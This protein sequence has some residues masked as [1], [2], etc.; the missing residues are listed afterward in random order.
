MRNLIWSVLLATCFGC[1]D[2]RPPAEVHVSRDSFPDF[3]DHRIVPEAAEDWSIMPFA[4]QGA[5]FGFGLPTDSGDPGVGFTGPFLTTTG[6]WF[7]PQLVRLEIPGAELV[8]ARALP[9]LLTAGWRAG[10]ITISQELWFDSSRVALIRTEIHNRG[11]QSWIWDAAWMG[12]A[13]HVSTTVDLVDDG[14]AFELANGDRVQVVTDIERGEALSVEPGRSTTLTIAVS[15][16]PAGDQEPDLPVVLANVEESLVSNA[17]RWRGY[18]NATAAAGDPDDP[19]RIVAVKAVQTLV[20]NWRGPA[21]R[22]AHGGLFPS[23]NVWYFNGFW[24]WD[25]WK[26]AVALARFAPEVAADQLR[27]MAAQQDESGMIADV[28][29][30]DPEEDNWRDTKPPLLGWALEEV[31]VA[32]GNLD[33]VR[34]LYPRLVDYHEFW[35]RDRDHDGDGLCEYGSTDGTLEAARWE[36]GMDNAVRFDETEMLQ[37]GPMAWSMD[38]ESVDLNSYLYREKIALRDLASVLGNPEDAERWDV[39]AAVLREHVQST[40]FDEDTGWFYDIRIDSGEIISTQGPEGWIPIWAGVATEEQAARLRNSMLDPEVFRT[41]VPFPTVAANNPEFS[42]GYWRGLVWLDQV[43]FAIEGLR[44]YGYS[45]DADALTAQVLANFGGAAIP[46]EPLYE[47]YHP[48]TGE[49]RNVRHFSWTAA[50]V[51]LL[52]LESS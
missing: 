46:G 32:T 44:A 38:Q 42:E 24:A 16:T 34:E 17:A 5:W 10:E 45:E 2:S 35:Y 48:L 11:Q 52:I 47:N 26:H 3:I 36:S 41:H 21:G 12:A 43:Y 22:F 30:L 50:H 29:Y 15:M 51:L 40:M 7:A 49:G 8:E 39:E 28:V 33:L 18:L 6:R 9:G 27:L 13:F 1:G 4:D 20:N 31:Y 23:S 19:A 14:I 37:N 25:S